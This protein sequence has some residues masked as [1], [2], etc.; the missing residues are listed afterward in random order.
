MTK[1]FR[2]KSTSTIS[3]HQALHCAP[4]TYPSLESS[5]ARRHFRFTNTVVSFPPPPD[6]PYLDLPIPC[7][8]EC[9]Y[10][11]SEPSVLLGGGRLGLLICKIDLHDHSVHENHLGL[12]LSNSSSSSV[13][14]RRE[15]SVDQSETSQS[16]VTS[17]RRQRIP[18]G[19][20]LST[21]RNFQRRR[22]LVI[23]LTCHQQNGEV[24]LP[25][26]HHSRHRR[27][28]PCPQPGEDEELDSNPW[29]NICV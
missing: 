15:D 13:P 24:D 11:P 12:S 29:R 25:E 27:L 10:E 2:T 4:H 14:G 23:N 9:Y 26:I 7:A 5:I 28:R 16:F 17:S 20:A 22:P 3:L 18:R 8:L 6:Y 1:V 21:H 19:E